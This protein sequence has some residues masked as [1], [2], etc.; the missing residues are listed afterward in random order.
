MSQG[1]GITWTNKSVLALASRTDP[2][3]A[4]RKAAREL[5]LKAKERGWEGPPFNPLH[6]AEML[7]VQAAGNSNIADARLIQTE[8][9]PRIEFNP[10]Q[11][12]ER[13]RFSIA[14]EVAHMLFPDWDQQIRNR[15]S[16]QHM[17]DGWQLEMLCNIAAAEFVLP[18]GSLAPL[19]TIPP[20]E[21]LM[22]ERRKFDVSAEAFLIRLA[23]ISTHPIGIFVAS[24]H[25]KKPQTRQYRVNYFISSPTAPHVNIAGTKIPPNSTIYKCTAIGYTDGETEKWITGTDTDVECVGIPAYPGNIYPRVAAL[26]RFETARNSLQP[27]KYVHGDV[28][29]PRGKG[30]KIVCQLVNNRATKWGGGVARK[31]AKRFPNA[32][33]SFSKSMIEI[34]Q[35]ERLGKTIFSEATDTITVASLIAQ[36]GYGPSPTP[37]IRYS[38]LERCI[39]EVTERAIN[40]D[41]SIHMPRIGTGASGGDW[42]IVKEMIDNLMVRADLPITVYDPPPK[43]IQMEL[44]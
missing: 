25:A 18:I 38:H 22:Q 14:H 8:T 37:R 17:G 39:H 26:V 3:C 5:V 10:Q 19:E 41:A 44:L 40:Y 1:R 20:I 15:G 43:R 2:V 34:P 12:R 6:I 27:V 29:A 9:G 28:L 4:I 7:D 24:A 13:V 30:E 33:K 23:N 36:E 16:Q 35:S 31:M 32:E 21:T 42:G 11:P